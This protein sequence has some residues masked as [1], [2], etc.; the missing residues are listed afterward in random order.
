MRNILL[1]D[2]EASSGVELILE[3]SQDV[4]GECSLQHSNAHSSSNSHVAVHVQL[5]V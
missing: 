3:I 5:L 1:E 2:V 4:V